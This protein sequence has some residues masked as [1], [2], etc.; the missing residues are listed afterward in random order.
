MVQLNILGSQKLVTPET[1]A[2]LGVVKPPNVFCRNPA[3]TA[4][5]SCCTVMSSDSV[6]LPN[7]FRVR[8]HPPFY[9][10]EMLFGMRL[11]IGQRLCASPLT[12]PLVPRPSLRSAFLGIG[13]IV[14]VATST[15]PAYI[16]VVVRLLIDVLTGTALGSEAILHPTML[17]KRLFDVLK[18]DLTRSASLCHAVI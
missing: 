4:A 14:S 16:S 2:A 7:L 5:L 17:G 10:G 13:V 6:P 11:M 1:Q 18:G 9:L 15:S 8:F 12:I 3:L